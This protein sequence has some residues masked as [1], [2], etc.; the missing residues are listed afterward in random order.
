LPEAAGRFELN[1]KLAIPFDGFGQ[2]EV[3]LLCADRRVAIEIDGR[4]HLAAA[5]CAHVF[6]IF[7]LHIS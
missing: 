6:Y 5:I 3:D 1:V 7:N 4:Q 2:M